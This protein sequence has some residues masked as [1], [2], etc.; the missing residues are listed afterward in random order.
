MKKLTFTLGLTFILLVA[1]E[2]KVIVNE[3]VVLPEYNN[4]NRLV[5]TDDILWVI[6]STPGNSDWGSIPPHSRILKVNLADDKILLSKEIPSSEKIA[7]NRDHQPILATYDGKVLKLNPDLSAEQL[8]TIPNPGLIRALECDRDNNIW[9]ATNNGGLYFYNGNDTLVF[10]SSNSILKYDW[11]SSIALDSES[12][13]WFLQFVDL[14]K[15]DPDRILSKDINQLPLVNP[16]GVFD[17]S[18]DN[19]NT[20]FASKWDGNFHRLIKKEKNSPWTIINPPKSSNNR[21]VKFIKSDSYGTIWIAYSIYPKD[22]LAY[23]NNDQWVEIEIPLEKVNI[24]DIET[25]KDK[26]YLGTSNGIFSMIK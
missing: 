13:I 8:F 6:S 21:P 5:R 15:I 11:I 2:K 12:N 9:V 17:L 16:T 23:Y 7:L 25:Y 3:T 4:I 22:V 18:S 10:N 1:C 20:L 19:H 26:I 14:Y 24:L